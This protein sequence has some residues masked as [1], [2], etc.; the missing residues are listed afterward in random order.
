MKHLKIHLYTDDVKIV[1]L[2]FGLALKK[3]I[4]DSAGIEVTRKRPHDV[5]IS[6]EEYDLV[7]V[8]ETISEFEL[9]SI[10]RHK[11]SSV[12][13]VIHTDSTSTRDHHTKV[14]ELSFSKLRSHFG[15]FLKSLAC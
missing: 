9:S 6:D 8:D 4:Y 7:F 12:I 5:F 10:L 1:D 15:D 13:R 3:N 2:I 11:S 14:Q